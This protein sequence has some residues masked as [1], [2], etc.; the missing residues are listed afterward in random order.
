MSQTLTIRHRQAKEPSQLPETVHPLIRRVLAQR[1]IT[2]SEQID[3]SLRNL[4]NPFLF[5]GMQAAVERLYQAWL[6]QEKIIIVGDFDADGATSVAVLMQGLQQMGFAHLQFEV[7]DRFHYGYGLSTAIVDD[8]AYQQAQLLITVD[9][10]ISSVEGVARAA[11]LGMDVII[12]DHHLP[13]DILPAACAIINPNQPNCGFPSKA[14]AGVGVAFYLLMGLRLYLRQ[15]EVFTQRQEP[16]LGELLD[17]VALGTVADVVPLDY[18]NRVLVKQGLNR[19]RAGR[20]RPGLAA[21]IE[22]ANKDY[23]YLASTDLGFSIA[24]RLN[25]AGR[26]DDMSQGVMLLLSESADMAQE[27]AQLLDEYNKE[28]RQIQQQMEAQAEQQLQSLALNE[29]EQ[30]KGVCLYDPDWHQGVVGLIASRVKERLY[31]PVI[32]F[33]EAEDGSLKGSGRSIA[34]IHLRDVLDAIAK[35]QPGLLEKF[36]GHAMAAG[37][38]LAKENLDRFRRAFDQQLQAIDESVFSPVLYSDGDLQVGDLNLY[39]AQALRDFPWGAGMA[40]PLFDGVMCVHKSQIIQEKHIKLWLSVDA[41]PERAV[42][43]IL[44][45]AEKRHFELLSE[46]QLQVYYRLDVNFFR[47]QQSLQLM[48]QD[49]RAKE[50]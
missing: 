32:A 40:E 41:K 33:A 43:A 20:M 4:P 24:P 7:P 12:T 27:L 37:L 15:Q 5:K 10:G 48:L 6:K 23:R 39:V 34:G 28:R 44:F 42:E 14:L 2:R 45:F 9:T 21:L 8:I 16:N 38:S 17:L 1:G 18:V 30:Y 35:Q 31:R 11:E 3:F 13:A 46:S 50:K 49:L 29:Q 25:A 47:G 26:L 36:G 19:I 22:V